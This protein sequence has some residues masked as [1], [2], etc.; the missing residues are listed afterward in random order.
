MESA[1]SENAIGY[2]WMEQLGG[3]RHGPTA[4]DSPNIGLRSPGFRNYVDYMQTEEFRA[5]MD[6]LVARAQR[7]PTAMLCAERLHFR[8]HRMLISDYLT[9]KGV[10]VLHIG[11]SASATAD[12]P[13]HHT[14]TSCAKVENGRLTYSGT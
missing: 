14:Y 13:T 4:P 6:D 9:V 1:L 11:S 2:V 10:E 5:A 3:R 7:A 8:C 12:S